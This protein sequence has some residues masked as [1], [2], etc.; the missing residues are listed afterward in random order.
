VKLDLDRLAAHVAPLIGKHRLEELTKGD[1]ERLR[2]SIVAGKTKKTEKTRKHGVRR[3]R[4]GAGTAARTLRAL[5]S[6]LAPAVDI[7]AMSANP[8][9]GVRLKPD[10]RR[11]RFLSQAEA[12]KLGEVLSRWERESDVSHAVPIIRLLALTGAR[13]G[14]IEALTWDQVDFERGLLVLAAS[15]SGRSVRPLSGPAL[16]LLS[17]LPRLSSTWVFPA[18]RA[19]GEGKGHYVGT[20]L[21][22]RRIRAE[23]G[24]DGVRLHDLRHSFA[25]FGAAGGLSLP[26][27][28]ALLGHKQASTTQRYAHIADDPA[29]KAADQVGGAVAAALG[30]AKGAA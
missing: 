19:G 14:E 11:E 9:R 24:L 21:A 4:G 5:A 25:S 16:Q 26:I 8:A 13:R 7:G 29:R 28:G 15:K 17:Q 18:T 2:D 30:V 12:R 10:V 3:V 23:A 27:I 6:V 20:P 22:W 1:I